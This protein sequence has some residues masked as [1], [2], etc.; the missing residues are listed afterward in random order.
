M[1]LGNL[2]NGALKDKAIAAGYFTALFYTF[3]AGTVFKKFFQRALSLIKNQS[4]QFVFLGVIG[5]I[6]V[7]A[8]IWFAQVILK[9]EG[10]AIS[11]HLLIDLMM[12]VPFYALLCYSLSKIIIQYRFSWITV[13]I[14]AG[15]YETMADGMIGNLFQLNILG[16]L[17]SPVLIPIFIV[18]YSPIILAPF[19]ITKNLFHPDKIAT[20]KDYL[21]LFRPLKSGLI[22][23]VSIGLGFLLEKLFYN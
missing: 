10:A 18:T 1:E 15:I 2:L 7:E 16:A 22:F 14:F 4:L 21:L 5:S 11:T 3:F 19:L 20:G 8:V 17:I 13:A 23:P 12:T 6:I 9:T